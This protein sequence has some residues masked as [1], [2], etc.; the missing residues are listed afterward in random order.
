[1]NRIGPQNGFTL[2]EA[3]IVISITAV[4]AAV[5]AVFIKKPFDAYVHTARRAELSDIADTAVRRIARDIQA[6]LPNSIRTSGTTLLEFVPIKN[7]GRYRA[8]YGVAGAGQPLM[9]FCPSACAAPTNTTFDIFGP[10]VSLAN[11]DWIVIYNLGI[12]G[13]DVYDGSSR[14]AAVAGN[15][16][17]AITYGGASPFP[18]SSPGS[19]FQ[20]VNINSSV[21][22]VCQPDT[23]DTVNA[24]N[25]FLYRYSGY[26]IQA[27]QPDVGALNTLGAARTMLASHVSGCS[28]T[29]LPLPLQSLGLVS[30]SLQLTE[31]SETVRLQH[32]VNVNNTP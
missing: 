25:G 16:L 2:V 18:F 24:S 27:A 15:N 8:D 26:P 4:L 1:M 29:Y 5:V 3:V 28:L 20:V 31:G 30:I 6:A 10:T 21:S 9:E 19:R 12:P 14:R 11:G 23:T 17:S 32:Q 7:A 22:Y 13:S